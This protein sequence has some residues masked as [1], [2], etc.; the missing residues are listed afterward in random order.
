MK[1]A[2]PPLHR[3]IRAEI[4]AR[5]VS[6]EWPPGTRIPAETELAATYGCARMTVNKALSELAADGLIERRRKSGSV[7]RQPVL[8]SAVLE[9]HDLKAEVEAAG[10]SY[11]FEILQRRQRRASRDDCERLQ[12]ETVVPVLA[13]RCLHRAGNRSFCL[14]D[15][16]ISLQA[17]PDAEGEAFASLS[18][19]AWLRG[20]VP[21][22]AAEHRISAVATDTSMA[23]LGLPL[24]APCLA[25]ERRTWNAD[26]PVTHVRLIYPGD[27]HA[28]VAHFTPSKAG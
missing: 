21:W 20:Q 3:R 4:E 10:F 8:Q 1:A 18:P 19:G 9:I 26:H 12:L 24:G 17:V 5:I 11:S 23:P 14:E 7:V 22:S 6:G 16:L 13:I 15:R 28:L 2:A 25:V 27:A